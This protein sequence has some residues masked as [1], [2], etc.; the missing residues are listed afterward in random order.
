MENK[1]TLSKIEQVY[2]K[3]KCEYYNRED[4][5]NALD[6][7]HSKNI[8]FFLDPHPKYRRHT[9]SEDTDDYTKHVIDSYF[10]QRSQHSPS[11]LREDNFDD[12]SS[13]IQNQ[14]VLEWTKKEDRYPKIKKKCK[15]YSVTDFKPNKQDK[16]SITVTNHRHLFNTEEE[17]YE[18][19][20]S[21]GDISSIAY[22]DG[23]EIGD[24]LNPRKD[25]QVVYKVGYGLL[26]AVNS[27]HN[28][29]SVKISDDC[30]VD[31][32]NPSP[33]RTCDCDSY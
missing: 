15:K 3:V 9:K 30:K 13:C 25:I 20:V 5:L 31:R 19:F 8:L 18:Y 24:K 26:M 29:I 4:A 6:T 16:F 27:Q 2:S 28:D 11:N 1:R 10:S 33:S 22:T 21:F 23:S 17:L 12:V 7:K 32:E 14:Q